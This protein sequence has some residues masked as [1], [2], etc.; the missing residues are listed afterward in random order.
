[1]RPVARSPFSA[2][3]GT[4][5]APAAGGWL[6][7]H[8]ADDPHSID[9]HHRIRHEVFVREQAIFA[10][11]DRDD[12]DEDAAAIKVLGLCGGVAAGAV[13]LYEIDRSDSVWQGDRLAVLQPY[14]RHGLGE[15]LVRYAVQTARQRGGRVMVAHI[16]PPNVRWFEHLG[17]TRSGGIEVYVGLPHQPMEIDLR[18]TPLPSL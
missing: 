14:R 6:A 2:A 4:T 10:D 15:P 3:D 18:R 7:C 17:W 16:Q 11:D 8:R 13:R 5:L 1:M 9:L 12:H